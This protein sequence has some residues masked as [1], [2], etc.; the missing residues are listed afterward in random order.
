MAV[1]DHFLPA[2]VR[3]ALSSAASAA[4]DFLH[5]IPNPFVALGNTAQELS[6]I[7]GITEFNCEDSWTVMVE[8]ALP[9][10]AGELKLLLVPQ[11]KQI[12]QNYLRPSTFGSRY[13]LRDGKRWRWTSDRN[14]ID[15]RRGRDLVPD[16][17]QIIAER[18]PGVGIYDGIATNSA[19]R[20]AF[21]GIEVLDVVGWYFLIAHMAE[22][23]TSKWISGIMHSGYCRNP[24]SS[25]FLIETYKPPGT[26]SLG[27]WYNS[28]Q[29][30]K[31]NI[32]GWILGL[33]GHILPK[34]GNHPTHGVAVVLAHLHSEDGADWQSCEVAIQI[35]V[36]H[37]DTPPAFLYS[38][39]KTFG[40]NE[41]KPIRMSVTL[42]N[43]YAL[44][45]RIS[46]VS[47]NGITIKSLSSQI[48]YFANP[49][50]TD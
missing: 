6:I 31:A 7:V 23:G 34:V 3:G 15:R 44:H 5:A 8:T 10:Y 33:K 9:A 48:R 1:D 24:S 2:W 21:A 40:P 41:T 45:F 49:G 39:S 37:E 42:T 28:H 25:G 14:D 16:V 50:A 43:V 30:T 13:K 11:P 46:Y 4:G 47:A 26:P 29:I 20:F 32:N 35:W 22:D 17:D 19:Y 18:L 12:L 38:V 27:L 36:V